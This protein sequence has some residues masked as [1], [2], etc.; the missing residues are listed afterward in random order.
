[1]SDT[2][3]FDAGRAQADGGDGD[4]HAAGPAM[5]SRD[6]VGRHAVENY[7]RHAVRI[8]DGETAGSDR[9]DQPDQSADSHL[10][11]SG[12]RPAGAGPGASIDRV[13]GGDKRGGRADQPVH[14]WWTLVGVCLGT[15]MLLIDVTI[16]NVALPDI[17]VALD[18]SFS[19]L[20][21]IIDAYALTLAALL[22]TAGSLA[23]L[24]GRRKLYVIGLVVFIGASGLCGA[25]QTTLMLALSRAVQ[26][27]G[28]AIMFSVSLA[29]LANA[30]RGKDRG[31]AFAI[32]GAITGLAVALGPLLGGLLTS[33]LNWRFIFFINVP[34]GLAAIGIVLF[35]VGESRGQQARRPDWAGFAIF[36]VALSALVFGLI[37]SNQHSFGDILVLG[38]LITAAALLTV[39]V[40]A[41]RRSEHAMFDLSLFAKPTFSGGS[42]AAFGISA[43]L[44]SVLVY[45]TLYLQNV[46]NLTPLQTGV[47]LIVL[48]AAIL[49]TS[50]AAGRL[51]SHIPIRLLIG[52]GLLAVAVGLFLM[53][54]LTATSTWTHLIPGLIVAGI[55]AGLVNPPLA[56]TAVG[57]VKPRNAGMASGINST[58]RQVGIATGIA[59]LGTLF[60]SRVADSV[61][62]AVAADPQLGQIGPRIADSLQ[63]GKIGALIKSLPSNQREQVGTL[64]KT[65]FTSGLDRILLVAA[66]VA[67][68]SAVASFFLIRTRDFVSQGADQS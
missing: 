57:V 29:L 46:L 61:R 44:F 2:T 52:P 8:P 11:A 37:E 10:R 7:G 53:R 33:G 42:I 15:F 41:E 63:S 55:G 48:S 1:M 14:K 17:Q 23:D 24:F 22:L 20:Q 5:S 50:S 16:V 18:S 66:I 31:T 67:A 6:H 39:F 12:A 40:F 68:V 60:R 64:A 28:G 21:W 26:G 58:F 59:L 49:V 32:W 35:R 19:A 45:I 47:R 9:G 4:S 43:T 3:T 34:I 65:A 62:S 27:I 38:P 54:G 30:F 56:Q 25:A 36:T 13:G 51:A